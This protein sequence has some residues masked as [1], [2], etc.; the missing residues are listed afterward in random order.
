MRNVVDKYVEKIEA[1]L[2]FVASPPPKIVPFM[3]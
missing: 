2:M 3:R 1:R